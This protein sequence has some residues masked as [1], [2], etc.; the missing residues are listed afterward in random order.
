MVVTNLPARGRNPLA[1]SGLLFF[2]F[3]SVPSRTRL[4]G[5]APTLLSSSAEPSGEAIYVP[6]RTG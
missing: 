3:F 6:T 1:A 5:S 2:D 4:G